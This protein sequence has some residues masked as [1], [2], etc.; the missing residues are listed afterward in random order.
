MGTKTW[1]SG[2]MI[3]LYHGS[4]VVVDSPLVGYLHFVKS[5]QVNAYVE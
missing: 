2:I 3:Q 5:A 1:H 4:N